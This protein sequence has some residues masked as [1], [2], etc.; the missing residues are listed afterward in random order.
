MII[1]VSVRE[2]NEGDRREWKEGDNL[3]G[4]SWYFLL[5]A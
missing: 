5:A 1:I 2:D 4:F 3:D